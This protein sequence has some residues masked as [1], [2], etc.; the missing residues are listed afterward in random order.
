[1]RYLLNGVC[2][3]AGT[4]QKPT[5]GADHVDILVGA[6]RAT[7]SY[8]Y[9]DIFF[10]KTGYYAYVDGV[11][12]SSTTYWQLFM[13]TGGKRPD[14]AANAYKN[15]TGTSGIT[16]CDSGNYASTSAAAE[17]CAR[18]KSGYHLNNGATACVANT[19]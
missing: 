7:A 10:C 16:N 5:V 4:A 11:K 19:T 17:S 13:C 9:S 15:C 12:T 2:A 18:C 14:S 1:M 8:T 3:V 6:T